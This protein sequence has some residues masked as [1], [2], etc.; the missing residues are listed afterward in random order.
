MP[1]SQD[2]NPNVVFRQ[3]EVEF[4]LKKKEARCQNT[5]PEKYREIRYN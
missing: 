4:I 3:P 1:Q 5:T 2:V